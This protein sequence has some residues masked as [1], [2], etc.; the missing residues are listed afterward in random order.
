L[1]KEIDTLKKE[2]SQF[3]MQIDENTQSGGGA[4]GQNGLDVPQLQATTPSDGGSRLH[5]RKF[6]S[7]AN[8]IR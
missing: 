5:V 1:A 3:Q 2:I 4:R 7:I 6:T 8:P